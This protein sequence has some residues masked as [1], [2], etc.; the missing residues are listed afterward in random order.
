M[1]KITQFLSNHPMWQLC[2]RIFVIVVAIFIIN[3]IIRIAFILFEKK[4]SHKSEILRIFYHVINKPLRIIIWII[5]LWVTLTQAITWQAQVFLTIL[6]ISYMAVKVLV[7]L[8]IAWALFSFAKELK[9]YF[10]SKNTRTDGG[11]NDFSMIETAHKAAQ[12]VILLFAFFSILSALNIPLMALAGMT[13][14]IACFIA[15]S[16]QELIKNLFVCV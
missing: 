3:I 5:G 15:I 4:L 11:Y 8:S 1:E 12:F 13:T 9:G 14:V 6:D 16:Q 7:I 10:I 2:F